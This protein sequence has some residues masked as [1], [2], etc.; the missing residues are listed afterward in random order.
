M[1]SSNIN[2]CH[3]PQCKICR[4]Q[5]LDQ[6]ACFYSNLPNK[7]Y[8]STQQATCKSSHCIYLISCKKHNC[9]MK[10]VGFTTTPI[11]K[12]L[13]G[14]RGNLTNNTEGVSLC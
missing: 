11:N 14:H 3:T 5:S 12:R 10:Y 13:S 1:E 8:Q 2:Y 6:N 4:L 7:K 9:H